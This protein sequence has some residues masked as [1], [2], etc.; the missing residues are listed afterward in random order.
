MSEE[1]ALAVSFEDVTSA[2]VRLKGHATRTSLLRSMELDRITGGRI[3]IKPECLQLSGSFK[4]RGAY[5][6]ISRLSGEERERGVVAFSSGNHGQGIALAALM[7]KVPATIVMPTDAPRIKLERT[8]SHGATIIPYDRERENREEIAN[9]IAA[10]TGA[11]LIPSYDDPFIIAGQGTSALEVTEDTSELGIA[12][13]A[14]LVCTGGG[15]L[16]A[17][18]CLV[19]DK[20]SPGTALYSVEPEHYDDH[21]R[22][23]IAGEILSVMEAPAPTICDALL[24]PRPGEMTFAINKRFAAGGLTVSDGEVCHAMKFALEYLNLVVEPGGAVALAA[25]L[26]GRLETRD[27]HIGLII[28]GGNVDT[29][30]LL[31]LVKD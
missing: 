10:E 2:A 23:F 1:Q 3:Y 26:A 22:S 17:G 16:L 28:T 7:E 24:S 14:Y 12:L 15:G 13:D 9:A 20:L 18:S 5:N 25:V 21:A 31:A 29:D 6:R 11:V 27:K 19:M 8:K 4:F 30:I